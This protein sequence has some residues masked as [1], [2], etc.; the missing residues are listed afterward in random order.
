MDKTSTRLWGL[1]YYYS[2]ESPELQISIDNQTGAA[3]N[4]IKAG[5]TSITVLN[6][7]TENVVI[8]NAANDVV[9]VFNSGV[10]VVVFGPT[11]VG[12]QGVVTG[13]T[14]STNAADM[15]V[16]SLTLGDEVFSYR[17]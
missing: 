15:A 3:P 12:Q 13:M 17:G 10:G 14:L 2:L 7:N 6:V 8:L 1:T 16:I 9:P 5:P 11:A 4:A